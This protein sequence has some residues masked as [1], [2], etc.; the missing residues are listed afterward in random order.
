MV[1][2]LSQYTNVARV[3]GLLSSSSKLRNQQI[4]ATT[5]A[6]PRYL[7]SAREREM[8]GCRLDDHEIK[9]SQ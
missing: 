6:T 9:L 1:L 7:A 4:S 3:R 5:L 2:T 8:V